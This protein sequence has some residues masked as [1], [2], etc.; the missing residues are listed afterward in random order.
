MSHLKSKLE[1]MVTQ[2]S[3]VEMQAL[4]N[5]IN[6]YSS[7]CVKHPNWPKD[8]IHQAAIIAEE[9]GE[10]IRASLKYEYENDVDS[11]LEVEA[12]QTGAMALRFLVNL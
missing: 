3:D 8:K 1:F 5:I 7:A 4:I 11:E 9:A 12:I 2:L 10:L 6:E